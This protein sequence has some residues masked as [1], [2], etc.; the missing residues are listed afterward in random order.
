MV[1]MPPKIILICSFPCTVVALASLK[2]EHTGGTYYKGKEKLTDKVVVI[3]GAN[4]GIGKETALEMARRDAK[5]IMAC[6]DMYKCEESRQN[7][8]LE[9]KNKY[10]Y[11][12]KCDLSSFESI[13]QF[14]D[15]FKKE[16]S[17]LH[18]LVNN[19]GVMR[20]P[21]S[22]T[23]D[24]I[25]TQLGV[26]HMGHFL[27][28]NLLLDRLKSSAPSRI[29]NVSSIAHRRGDI[30]VTDLNSEKDYDP[31]KAYAQSKLANI[32]FTNELARKLQGTGVTANAV[33]P[34]IVDTDII[35][36]MGFY[37]STFSKIFLYPFAWPFIKTPKQGAQTCIYAALDPSLK[38]VS[39]TSLS[40]NCEEADTAPQAK[41][42][43][44]AKWLW[45]TSE[46]WTRLNAT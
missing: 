12:R 27:L 19:G 26:N 23:A 37:N 34:G 38:D 1:W 44:L 18:I 42:E 21:K 22:T 25:E 33:H 36:H 30:D 7:I 9:T 20:C 43:K 24:G 4:T 46:K 28:T 40:S 3:T 31:A 16:Q 11:C 14:V 17:K 41:D 29:I 45:L 5:V 39:G 8:V 32:L 2:K 13:R 10:V 35:R 15:R 6:R